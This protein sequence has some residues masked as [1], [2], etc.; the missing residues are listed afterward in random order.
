MWKRAHETIRLCWCLLQEKKFLPSCKYFS[1][2]KKLQKL[3]QSLVAKPPLRT[4]STRLSYSEFMCT[5]SQADKVVDYWRRRDLAERTE[6]KAGNLIGSEWEPIFS[7]DHGTRSIFGF[8][9]LEIRPKVNHIGSF[10]R[11][12]HRT[13]TVKK[14][15]SEREDAPTLRSRIGCTHH[16]SDTGGRKKFHHFCYT[17]ICHLPLTPPISDK[18]FF[19]VNVGSQKEGK[20]IVNS[21]FLSFFFFG[22]NFFVFRTSL[23]NNFLSWKLSSFRRLSLF[24]LLTVVVAAWHLGRRNEELG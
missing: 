24:C 2:V 3:L 15:F 17:V 12:A 8:S 21:Y 6:F 1:W 18:N 11:L 7:Q 13:L 4:L 5:L 22:W 23:S 20:S 19:H 9:G 14:T 16:H 10:R